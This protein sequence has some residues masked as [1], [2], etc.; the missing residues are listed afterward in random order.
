MT[1][2]TNIEWADSTF[3][4]W[5]GCTKVGPGCDHCYAEN[6]NARFGGGQSQ[7]WGSGA[8]RR[9]TSEA[10]WR[11][12]MQWNDKA[13]HGLFVQCDNC[14]LRE[15]RKWDNTIPPGGLACCS[16]PNCTALPESESSPVRPRVFCASL[17]DW[18][19]NEV[20]IEWLVDLLD[21]IRQTPNLDWLLLTK[22]IGSWSSRLDD[23]YEYVVDNPGKYEPEELA[24]W[25]VDWRTNIA[26]KNVWIGATVINQAEADRDIPKLLRV[27][28]RVRFL[29]IEPMLGPVRLK[30]HDF[31]DRGHGQGWIGKNGNAAGSPVIDWVI[32]GG[33]SGPHARPI[34]ASWV[35]SL[36]DQCVTS[37]VPFLFKQWGE[38]LPDDQNPEAIGIKSASDVIRV[39]KKKA[40]RSIDGKAWTQFPEQG[41][42]DS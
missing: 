5:E 26:P 19:D 12:P 42:G 33:E 34:Y 6:R 31:S 15:F 4:P 21:T 23:A 8:P 11:K 40:G 22:R 10:N 35:K 20:P 13:G 37:E 30:G 16:N 28:A 18:L 36:R 7:N 29:S 24:G 14:G 9:R 32:C 2:S 38:W 25:I 39:G 3:N 27:P 1:E 17:A 41:G